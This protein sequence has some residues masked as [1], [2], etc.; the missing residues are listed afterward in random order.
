MPMGGLDNAGI[1]SYCVISV[2]HISITGYYG[3]LRYR[4]YINWIIIEFYYPSTISVTYSFYVRIPKCL[5][6]IFGTWCM[7][8][9]YFL[10]KERPYN[11]CITIIFAEALHL[12]ES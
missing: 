10:H 9:V 8:T 3:L 12:A 1:L 2:T 5:T 6:A 7:H 11:D 4:L